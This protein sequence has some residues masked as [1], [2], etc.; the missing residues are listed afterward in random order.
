MIVMV[1]MI[2]VVMMI[3][4]IMLVRMGMVV[5]MITGGVTIVFLLPSWQSHCSVIP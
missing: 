5:V 3:V 2:V 1:V 4:M